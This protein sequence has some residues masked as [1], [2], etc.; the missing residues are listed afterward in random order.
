METLNAEVGI[1]M[2]CIFPVKNYHE[3]I[4]PDCDTDVLILSALKHIISYGDDYINRKA[5]FI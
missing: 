2:N 1:P 3:E 4:D 5:E